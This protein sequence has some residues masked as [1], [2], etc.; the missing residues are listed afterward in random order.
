MHANVAEGLRYTAADVARALAVQTAMQRRWHAFFE[1]FDVV[2]APAITITPRP[3]SELY[4]A[5][6]DGRVLDS[7]YHWLALAYAGTLAG[8]P[9]LSLPVGLDARG[10]RSGCS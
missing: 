10:C 2:L 3:W 7:Y 9:C 4:P 8:H 5:E 6:I 1:P